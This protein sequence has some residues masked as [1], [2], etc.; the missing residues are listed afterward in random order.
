MDIEF[1][2]CR[3]KRHLEMSSDDGCTPVGI[4]VILPN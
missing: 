3:M 2:C 4:Y 1:Q